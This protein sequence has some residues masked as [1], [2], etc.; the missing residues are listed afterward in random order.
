[1][2]DR[3]L[4][5][6]KFSED[7][8]A[9]FSRF[10]IPFGYDV[11]T[12]DD[13][14]NSGEPDYTFRQV[15]LSRPPTLE[16]KE[17]TGPRWDYLTTE[18]G[19]ILFDQARWFELEGPGRS[20]PENPPRTSFEFSFD[21]GEN[22]KTAKI[23]SVIVILF[24]FPSSQ[25]WRP[26]S[27][28]PID[29]LQT[30]FLVVDVTFVDVLYLDE[31]MNFNECFRYYREPFFGHFED[32]ITRT[33]A[34]GKK[35]FIDK[36]NLGRLHLAATDTIELGRNNFYS[37]WA[38][39]LEQR[40]QT[41]E[42]NFE[43]EFAFGDSDEKQ[44]DVSEV[45]KKGRA[46]LDQRN[47]HPDN[48]AFVWTCAILDEDARQHDITAHPEDFVHWVRLLNIDGV[49]G[50]SKPTEF[51]KVWA[52]ARTYRR[53]EHKGTYYGFTS[54][55]G[56]MLS[57]PCKEPPTHFHWRYMYF[58]QI[59]FLLYLRVGLF[60]FSAK[61]NGISADARKE[62]DGERA[63]AE[64]FRILRWDLAL[65]T[66]LYQFPLLSNQQQAVEMY[67]IARKHMDVNELFEEVQKEVHNSYE[68]LEQKEAAAQSK[69]ANRQAVAANRLTS[70][71][72]FL[73]PASLLVGLFGMDD[74]W[75]WFKAENISFG[76]RSLTLI[77]VIGVGLLIGYG[78]RRYMKALEENDD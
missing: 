35:H 65:F 31:L 73:I 26:L 44:K 49:D 32:Q 14:D 66:N 40:F 11:K 61:L 8:P 48:R 50:R 17:W 75:L 47:A 20:C 18:T 22:A 42:G 2:A 29:L 36:V 58:D 16:R 33:S 60:R 41:E 39:L 15:N 76:E 55:S 51:E 19:Q 23:E 52:E 6:G 4:S 43:L 70:L 37:R 3:L 24:D 34:P 9:S 59:L 12:G 30:G 7:A 5:V 45:E 74:K 46:D 71:A 38:K 57:S 10:V 63:W 54:H 56:A 28:D 68:F 77:A 62:K 53:W 25:K 21:V 64:S 69:A 67:A 78:V 13:E 27:K 1:M 72:A